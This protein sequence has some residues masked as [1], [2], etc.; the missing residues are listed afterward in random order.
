MTKSIRHLIVQVILLL[1]VANASDDNKDNSS[2]SA[3]NL[4]QLEIGGKHGLWPFPLPNISYER[5]LIDHL[6]LGTGI[7]FGD[8]AMVNYG[9][10]PEIT[11]RQ[12]RWQI[13]V[14]LLGYYGNRH[15]AIGLAGAS[16]SLTM[17]RRVDAYAQ[18]ERSIVFPRPIPFCG[19]GYEYRGRKLVFRV[20][21]YLVVIG[22]N[23]WFPPVVP[24][25]GIGFGFAF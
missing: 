11:E 16:L 4:V 7:A 10:V 18:G 3:K 12:T 5:V 23:A 13:P 25:A 8:Y 22:D 14:Y 6:A 1:L 9:G 15:R 17:V 20:P 24:W 21:A 2:I 19:V